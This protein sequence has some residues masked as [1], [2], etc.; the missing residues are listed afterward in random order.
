MGWQRPDMTISF[1]MLGTG[2]TFS[3]YVHPTWKVAGIESLLEVVHGIGPV[4]K[5]RL[6]YGQCQL[7]RNAS[8][9]EAGVSNDCIIHV[10]L[11][12]RGD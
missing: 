12:I 1:K 5:L 10:M 4:D 3:L 11:M 2:K 9:R 7:Q 6:V 8:L